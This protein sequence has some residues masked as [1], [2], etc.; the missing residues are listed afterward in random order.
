VSVEDAAGFGTDVM[1][2]LREALQLE[3]E[4]ALHA[5]RSLTWWGHR[6]AQQVWIDL[7]PEGDD[8]GSCRVHV[9]TDL[10][11][12]VPPGPATAER[13]SVLNRFAIL[14]AIVCDTERGEVALH[15]AA[16]MSPDNRGWV[17]PLLL[18]AITLQA[19][20]AHAEV[21]PW[22][23]QLGGVPAESSHPQSGPRKEP[24]ERLDVLESV[25]A[26]LGADASPF[27]EADME[28][29]L[30]LDPWA[31]A[32]RAGVGVRAEMEGATFMVSAETRHPQIGA[33]AHLRVAVRVPHGLEPAA[34]ALRLNVAEAREAMEG[35][36][37]GAWCGAADDEVAF[38]TFLPAAVY[39]PGLLPHLC[40]N[41][42]ERARWAQAWLRSGPPPGL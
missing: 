5:T 33:G 8:G 37:F 16:S 29:V 15:A 1:R 28:A 4:W 32:E 12:G 26:R 7:P 3:E 35:H 20:Q 41:A 17:E 22:G 9:S 38:V 6:L 27:T 11:G 10:L 14:S 19:A 2:R 36:L 40:V 39:E 30:G 13:I 18:S 23:Q 31:T 34:T 24:A 42:A 25:F 21:D